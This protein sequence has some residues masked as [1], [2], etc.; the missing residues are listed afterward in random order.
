MEQRRPLICIVTSIHPDF[1]ARIFKHAKAA[2]AMGYEVDIVCPWKAGGFPIP[3]HVRLIAFERVP[4]RAAR[5][6]LVPARIVRLLLA[7]RYALYHFHDLDLLWIMALL[8]IFLRR[9]VI[10]DCHE[11]YADEMGHKPYLPP[12][13]RP[14]LAF[15]VRWYERIFASIVRDV[16]LVVPTQRRTFKSAWYRTL[17]VRNFAELALEKERADDLTTRPAACISIASQYVNN[18]AL[19]VLEVARAVARTHPEVKFYVVDRYGTDAALRAR[20]LR[21]IE[22]P[23]LKGRVVMLPNV[24][25]PDI[26]KNLNRGTIGL[27]LGLPSPTLEAGLPTKLFEYMAAGL[28]VVAADFASSRAVVEESHCGILVKPGDVGGF[29]DAIVSLVDDPAGAAAAG[30]R[31]L[32]AFR[33]RYNWE[34]EMTALAKTYQRLLPSSLTAE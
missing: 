5:L 27:T 32:D 33:L 31:G 10:Y 13:A 9:P 19:L 28:P 26:M 4:S 12:W 25:P 30:K 6:F 29:R 3:P 2:A 23:D 17:L 7:R 24:L 1:D 34:A 18:G 15:V 16:V 8:K 11:N 20:V 14:L 22:E 21:E